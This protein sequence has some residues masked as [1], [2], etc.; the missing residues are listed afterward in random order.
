MLQICLLMRMVAVLI[1]LAASLWKCLVSTSRLHF[2]PKT[3]SCR[4]LQNLYFPR[5]RGDE[6]GHVT[7][8]ALGLLSSLNGEVSF[9][10][11][12]QTPDLETDMAPVG[13]RH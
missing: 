8:L 9:F 12:H 6:T 5:V 4:L 2:F 3:N 11:S 10:A 7:E 1:H 13:I